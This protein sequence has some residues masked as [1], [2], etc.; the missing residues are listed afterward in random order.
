MK[1]G[2]T[3]LGFIGSTLLELLLR[4]GH[5]VV[6]MDNRFKENLDNV[7]PFVTNKKF[8]FI[9]GD[10]TDPNYVKQFY[11]NDLDYVVTTAGVVGFPACDRYKDLAYSVNVKGSENMVKYKP[12]NVG[13]LYTS[14]GSV[15]KPGQLVCTE[16]SEV[17]PPSWYGK[18]KLLGEQIVL[19]DSR[20][21][22]HRYATA[23]GVGFSTLRVNLLL[24]DLVYKAVNDKCISI[25]EGS[26]RRVFINIT[27]LVQAIYV[28][29]DQFENLLADENKIYNIGNND[30]SLTKIEVA[31][32]IQTKTNCHIVEVNNITDKDCRDYGYDSSKFMN[33]TGW[34]PQIGIEETIDH[35]IK[36]CPLLTPWSRY[37]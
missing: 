7:I 20:G 18:T 23:C 35:L 17:D 24:N 16:T 19:S 10:I 32:I 11:D 12:A 14:T 33:T 4:N 34:K 31:R 22:A 25:F 21:L 26:F 27:D 28:T 37:N 2:I 30:L 36:I 8:K 15:Y 29:L 1:I 6:T 9:L 13:I 5:E 3:G